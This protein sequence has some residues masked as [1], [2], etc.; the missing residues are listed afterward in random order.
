MPASTAISIR[1]RS[2]GCVPSRK[3]LLTHVRS[4]NADI[5][6]DIRKTGD[7]SDATAAKLKSAVDGFAKNFA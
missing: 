3:G 6:E 4:Q 5:L 7:L 1:C 2:T